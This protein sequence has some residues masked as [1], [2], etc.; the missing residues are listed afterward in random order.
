MIDYQTFQQ[1]R[2]LADQ[3]QLKASQIA[4]ELDLDPKTVQ[5]WIDQPRYQPRQSPKRPSQ[6]DEVFHA[7]NRPTLRLL[8]KGVFGRGIRPRSR[9]RGRVLFFGEVIHPPLPPS[10]PQID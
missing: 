2:L 3:K 4:L 6:L 10:S 7:G 1:V 5:K 9:Q 8:N